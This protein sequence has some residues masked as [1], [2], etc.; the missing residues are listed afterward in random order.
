MGLRMIELTPSQYGLAD[1]AVRGVEAN[2]LFA[3]AVVEHRVRGRVFADDDSHPRTCYVIH[4]YG[5]SML[6]GDTGS[7]A[8]NAWLLAR[9][10]NEDHA[11]TTTEWMQAFPR[12]WDEVLA[13]MLGDR[14]VPVGDG[15]D[16]H[17]LVELN[18]R[19]LFRFDADAFARTRPGPLPSGLEVRRATREDVAAIHGSVVPANFWD[20]ADEFLAHGI[21]F[22]LL[23]HG[24]PAALAF[25]SFIH[26]DRLELG[27]ETLPEQRG[28]GFG[29]LACAALID[30]CLSTGM[31]P[32][33]ACREANVP[34]YRLALALGFDVAQRLPYYRLSP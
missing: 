22:T 31:T 27:V 10:L 28:R 30:H 32:V 1:P 6:V 34:S 19:V 29:R 14:L 23:D 7:E 24:Q 21:G 12:E 25:S 18:T 26:D 11:R 3:R 33:W 16:L 4:P 2:N 8:F 13:T 5:M 17:G 9:A 20:G 15:T